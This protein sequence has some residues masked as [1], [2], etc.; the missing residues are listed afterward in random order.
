MY[1]YPFRNGWLYR[2][3]ILSPYKLWYSSRACWIWWQYLS[4]V[5][6]DM[7]FHCQNIYRLIDRKLYTLRH[8]YIGTFPLILISW[9]Y[10]PNISHELRDTLNTIRDILTFSHAGSEGRTVVVYIIHISYHFNFLLSLIVDPVALK[11]F[12]VKIKLMNI[13]TTYSHYTL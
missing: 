8:S 5:L 2:F 9:T 3:T 13:W 10:S 1:F 12:N 6:R 7:S 4:L 11:N